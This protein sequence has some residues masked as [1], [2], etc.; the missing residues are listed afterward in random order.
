MELDAVELE[1]C[2]LLDPEAVELIVSV[3]LET[4]AV[5]LVFC[6]VLDGF[7][8]LDVLFELDAVEFVV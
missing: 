1:I 6:V 5:E 7:V 2:V 3:L 8:E 4:E